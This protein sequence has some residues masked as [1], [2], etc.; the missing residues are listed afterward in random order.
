[1]NC[2]QQHLD[3]LNFISHNEAHL[4]IALYL[5]EEVDTFNRPINYTIF[6]EKPNG[7]IPYTIR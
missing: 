7:A 6:S 3:I 1:M 4:A 2:R 5:L